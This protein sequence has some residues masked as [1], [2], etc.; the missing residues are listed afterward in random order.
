METNCDLTGY[1]KV[2][3]AINTNSCLGGDAFNITIK[4]L[5]IGNVSLGTDS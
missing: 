5:V 1:S 2:Y 3:S 4:S